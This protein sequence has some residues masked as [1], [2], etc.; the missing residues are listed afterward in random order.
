MVCV[1]DS[2]LDCFLVPL[3]SDWGCSLS[4]EDEGSENRA[5]DFQQADRAADQ[6]GRL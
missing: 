4:K 3:F 1:D 5:P 2:R 6:P